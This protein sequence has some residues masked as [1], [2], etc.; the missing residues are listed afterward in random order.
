MIWARLSAGEVITETCLFARHIASPKSLSGPLKPDSSHAPQ[1][2]GYVDSMWREFSDWRSSTLQR[3]LN[4]MFVLNSGALLACLTL[5]AAKDGALR[6]V[7]FPIWCFAAGTILVVIHAASDFYACERLFGK[8]RAE[9]SQFFK[10]E[11]DWEVL[12]DRNSQR[13]RSDWPWHVLGWISGIAFVS[14]LIVGLSVFSSVFHP[15][16]SLSP[17]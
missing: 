1:W 13:M 17:Q 15:N 9:V 4:Y 16:F 6:F 8:F 2:S 11:I 14:G 10:N 5:V 12:V 3:V 7:R